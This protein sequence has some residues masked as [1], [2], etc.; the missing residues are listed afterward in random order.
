MLCLVC[1]AFPR[2]ELKLLDD[3]QALQQLP[4]VLRTPQRGSYSSSQYIAERS[5]LLQQQHVIS[6]SSSVVL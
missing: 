1:V 5:P 4:A 3:V 6:C 2:D